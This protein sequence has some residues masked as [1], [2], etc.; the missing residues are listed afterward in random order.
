MQPGKFYAFADAEFLYAIT[1]T[2]TT[3]LKKDQYSHNIRGGLAPGL[4]YLINDRVSGE[5]ALRFN[6]IATNDPRHNNI[7]T[8]FEAG[9]NV[10]LKGKKKRNADV[11]EMRSTEL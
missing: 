2:N 11:S 1:W 10:Y 5:A 8:A 4:T 6:Y 7:S 3:P 9:F